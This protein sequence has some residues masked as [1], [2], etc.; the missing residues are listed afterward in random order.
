VTGPSTCGRPEAQL[1]KQLERARPHRAKR[2]S[3]VGCVGG[4]LIHFK[5]DSMG[6][7]G[8][9]L[10]AL[11]HAA[12]FAHYT[13]RD[14]G[15]FVE[16]GFLDFMFPG[17]TAICIGR[18]AG[19][20]HVSVSC[21][22]NL[23][24][25]K[26][27]KSHCA[28]VPPD[29]HRELF[30]Q[31]MQPYL[32]PELAYC[33][34]SPRALDE[35]RLL[36]VHVRSDDIFGVHENTTDF[37]ER[38]HSH[39]ALEGRVMAQPPCALY[40]TVIKQNRYNRV[41][42]ISSVDKANPC[43]GEWLDDYR[44]RAINVA[45]EPMRIDVQTGNITHDVC[46]MLKARHVVLSDSSMS[47]NLMGISPNVRTIYG[48]RGMFMDENLLQCDDLSRDVRFQLYETPRDFSSVMDH[49]AGVPLNVETGEPVTSMRGLRHW[50]TALAVGNVTGPSTCG[51]PE[52]QLNKQLERAGPHRAKRNVSRKP[53]E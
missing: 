44:L 21:P 2:N 47:H 34:S 26:W 45:G 29:K 40:E 16:D 13:D 22:T 24:K 39:H 43:L 10:S 1:N 12:T 18:D 41:L 32:S 51:R 20:G 46:A 8:T 53:Q 38:Q 28:R 17:D 14:Q 4:T 49:K 6:R 48:E 37:G 31:Y 7:L 15:V 25:I 23:T 50:L 5:G 35:E 3:E 9:R 19:V 52:A 33:L 36:T 11:M 27:Y 42:M 30:R